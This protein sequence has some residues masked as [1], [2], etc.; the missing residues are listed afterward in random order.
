MALQIHNQKIYALLSE[1]CIK[2]GF[3]IPP[4][5]SV[6]LQKDPPAD[7]DSFTDAI[8]WAEGLAPGN[9]VELRR[10]VRKVVEKHFRNM[11]NNV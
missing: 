9:E 11:D 4:E 5:H 10:E 1:L 2:L 7:I 3:C 8:F 6:R